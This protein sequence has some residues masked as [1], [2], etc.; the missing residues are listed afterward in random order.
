[1]NTASLK[2]WFRALAPIGAL[3]EGGVT[4]LA[5]SAEE[6]LMFGATAGIA[7]QIGLSVTEDCAGN[8]FISFPG[9]E[10]EPCHLI[11]SHLE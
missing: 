8:M 9:R 6:D 3:P 2:K 10:K 5:Y 4:R 11:C 7:R 1:M